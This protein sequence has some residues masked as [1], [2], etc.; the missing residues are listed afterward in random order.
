MRNWK[1]K[2]SVMLLAAVMM[3]ASGCGKKGND[4]A[5]QKQTKDTDRGSDKG[6]GGG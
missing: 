6:K 4:A 2:S 3:F 1:M 5:S